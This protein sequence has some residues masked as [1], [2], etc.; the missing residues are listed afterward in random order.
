MVIEGRGAERF[1]E[2]FLKIIGVQTDSLPSIKATKIE[3]SKIRQ[4]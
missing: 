1:W 2:Y 4:T 3:N